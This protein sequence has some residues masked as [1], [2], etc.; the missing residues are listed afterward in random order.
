MIADSG[1]TDF[2]GYAVAI[3]ARHISNEVLKQLKE[4][5]I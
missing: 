3:C 1:R 2:D 4:R 5:D